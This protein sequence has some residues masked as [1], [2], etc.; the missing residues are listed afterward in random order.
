MKIKKGWERA[1]PQGSAILQ[2]S[3]PPNSDWHEIGG[4]VFGL[5][6]AGEFH[7]KDCVG[8]VPIA[9]FG[10]GHE[11]NQAALESAEATF[12]FS[13]GLRSWGNEMRDA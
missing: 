10:V 12:D 2:K 9:H 13:F 7:L 8:L 1:G 4:S 6:L 3:L 5:V 11:S